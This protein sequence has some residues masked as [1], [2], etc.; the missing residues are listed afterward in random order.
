[1]RVTETIEADFTAFVGA[2]TPAPKLPK[3]VAY[4]GSSTSEIPI[5]PIALSTKGG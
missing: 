2:G 3:V 1:M 5:P 4:V